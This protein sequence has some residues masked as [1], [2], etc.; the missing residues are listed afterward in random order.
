MPEYCAAKGD[1]NTGSCKEGDNRD[2]A[3][4][5]YTEHLPCLI[6]WASVHTTWRALSPHLHPQTLTCTCI[7]PVLYTL[8]LYTPLLYTLF[9]Y[10]PFRNC[11]IVVIIRS[12]LIT[13]SHPFLSCTWI[14][15]FI[16]TPLLYINIAIY[17]L[18]LYTSFIY[19]PFLYTPLLYTPA[20]DYF[21]IYFFLC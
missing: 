5:L 1:D 4:V 8:F 17:K 7:T 13:C 10:T 14:T 3:I 15:P 19:A 2:P 20:R 21:L 16:Y 6:P 12:S 9:I 11:S 18:F